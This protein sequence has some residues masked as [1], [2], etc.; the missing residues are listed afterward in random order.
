MELEIRVYH[1]N[2]WH[3]VKQSD[4]EF[5]NE[6]LDIQTSSPMSSLSTQEATFVVSPFLLAARHDT[7][8]IHS[9][10]GLTLETSAS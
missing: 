10:E 5:Q 2:I 8:Q 1:E 7:Y 9:N 6:R 4:N 3:K